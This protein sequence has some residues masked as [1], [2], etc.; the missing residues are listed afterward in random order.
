MTWLRT[1]Q[2]FLLCLIDDLCL[3]GGGHVPVAELGID[4]SVAEPVEASKCY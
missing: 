3:L 2:N 1:K 4:P